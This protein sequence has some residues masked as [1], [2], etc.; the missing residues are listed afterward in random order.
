[1]LVVLALSALDNTGANAAWVIVAIWTLRG[2][3]QAVEGLL[4][5][6][7]LIF[8]NPV[9][10]TISD[11]AS[12]A[13]WGI[14]L[15]ATLQVGS[16]WLR[17]K[18]LIPIWIKH[19]TVF[20]VFA[21]VVA[22]LVSSLPTVSLFKLV[23]F[24]FGTTIIYI[25]IKLDPK[26]NWSQT[27]IAYGTVIT[28]C[29]LPLIFSAQGY[30]RNNTQFQGILSHPQSYGVIISIP[31]AYAIG[32]WFFEKNNFSKILSISI[33]SVMSATVLLSGARSGYLAAILAIVFAFVIYKN[34]SRGVYRI[35][36]HPLTYFVLAVTIVALWQFT[37]VFAVEELY[38][39]EM[40]LRMRHMRCP[41]IQVVLFLLANLLPHE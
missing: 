5:S 30:V 37:P 18:Q 13:R 19:T 40:F 21:G 39:S 27:L 22:I 12:V 17:S 4:L 14:L 7:L 36:F 1:M 11:Y 8:I 16:T 38:L 34:S 32:K 41:S 2:P 10:F 29:S 9:V 6:M 35:I 26:K 33:T 15:L 24:L 23:S 28:I 20:V 31:L 3:G 25:G